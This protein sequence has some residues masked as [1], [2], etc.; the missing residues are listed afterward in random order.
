MVFLLLLYTSS[1]A[2]ALTTDNQSNYIKSAP[3]V[4]QGENDTL[5]VGSEQDYPPFATGLTDATAGGFTVDLWKAV[6]DEMGLKY[7]I[8]VRPFHELLKEFKAGKIDVLINLNIIDELNSYADFSVPHAIVQGGI[9]VRESDSNI[10]S[11]ADLSGKSII[12]MAA[13]VED[14]YAKSMGLGKQLILVKN[15]ENGLRLLA[16]G[17]HDAM[18]LSKLVGTQILQDKIITNIKM[19]KE[20]SGFTQKFAFAVHE[21]NSDLLGKINEGLALSKASGTYDAL[22]EKWFGIY[23]HEGLNWRDILKYLSPFLFL[24]LVLAQY[25]IYRRS[26]ERKAAQK[27][28]Q[29]SEAHL[30]LSQ[31]SGGIGTWEAD[32]VNNTQHWSESCISLLGLQDKKIPLGMIS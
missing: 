21:G 25:G 12:M 28:L 10:R 5:I 18:L 24:F 29:E 23:E 30:R 26:L 16:S 11:Q 2:L 9:F 31:V 20:N 27:A 7:S 4:I 15:A 14:K 1:V 6:A 17:K 8:R 19:L 22:Y 32:L 3:T 13:D